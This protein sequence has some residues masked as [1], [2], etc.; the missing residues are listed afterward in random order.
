MSN[1]VIDLFGNHKIIP[2]TG[3]KYSS[4][5]EQFLNPFMSDFDNLEYIED[6]IEFAINAW[7]MANINSIMS[8]K[9]AEKAM[10]SIENDK[11]ILLL[12][13][14][15]AHKQAKFKEY[16]NFIV[17]FELKEVNDGGDPIL[18]VITQDEDAYLTNMVNKMEEVGLQNQENFEENYINRSAIIVKPKQPFIDWHNNLY[19]DSKM[20]EIDI[21]IYLVNDAIEDLEKFLK[22]K[23]DKIFTMVLEDWH[24]NKKEWPQRRNYKMFNQWFRVEVSETIYDLEKEPVLKSE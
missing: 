5:L 12:K 16:T 22:K 21:D 17:D 6:I 20:D 18:S 23:F 2:N 9:D 13:K 8:N 24:T 15:I 3:V 10:N 19:P 7:N 4:L 1:K 11:D 14:M